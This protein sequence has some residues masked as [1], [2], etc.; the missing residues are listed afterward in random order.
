MPGPLLV[1]GPVGRFRLGA[2][3]HDDVGALRPRNRGAASAVL[4]TDLEIQQP[5]REAE[6]QRPCARVRKVDVRVEVA[7]DEPRRVRL[8]IPERVEVCEPGGGDRRAGGNGSQFALF[9]LAE[10]LVESQELV[11]LVLAHANELR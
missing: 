4:P 7:L 10:R 3:V 9:P 6:G 2:E 1:L 11:V 8:E 5:L